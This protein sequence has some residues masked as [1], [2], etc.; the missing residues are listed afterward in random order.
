MDKL[1]ASLCNVENGYGG[2]YI[3]NSVD[4]TIEGN[5][6]TP[7][8]ISDAKAK[9]WIPYDLSGGYDERTELY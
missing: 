9:H 1:I 5:K 6:Y 8:N 7:Q 2:F 3:I 4:S